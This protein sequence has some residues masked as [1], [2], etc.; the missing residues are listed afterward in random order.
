M[1]TVQSVSSTKDGFGRWTVNTSR[2]GIRSSKIIHA[3]NG[4]TGQMLLEYRRSI[5]PIRGIC[6]HI[7]SPRGTN[8]SHLNNTY[9]IR[10]DARNNDYLIP[11]PDGSIVVGGARQ[12]FWHNKDRW[13]DTTNDDELVEEA[14]SYF[15]N[16]MQRLFRGWGNSEA[17]T[18][19]VW[20]GSKS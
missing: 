18:S 6:S 9:G 7:T 3:T 20:T 10:F 16:Y 17:K 12:R 13:F 5:T 19:Q 11:R 8:V 1:T 4:Y 14:V 15:D 2:G